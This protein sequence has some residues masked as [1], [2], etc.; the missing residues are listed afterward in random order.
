MVPSLRTTLNLKNVRV[1]PGL[2]S[3]VKQVKVGFAKSAYKIDHL[4]N[5]NSGADIVVELG[6]RSKPFM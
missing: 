3:S 2:I 4:A 5:M 1:N 6:L